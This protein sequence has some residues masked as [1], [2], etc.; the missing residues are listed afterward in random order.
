MP[1]GRSRAFSTNS[2]GI[3]NED[4]DVHIISTSF[5]TALVHLDSPPGLAWDWY[6]GLFLGL[7]SG[8]LFTA[9]NFFLKFFSLVPVEMLLVR[10]ALQAS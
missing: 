9:N 6:L 3:Y 1:R 7:F 5:G 10:S 2:L 8:V 4:G